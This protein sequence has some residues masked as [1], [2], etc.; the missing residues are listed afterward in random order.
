MSLSFICFLCCFIE[1]ETHRPRTS[2][3]ER[4]SKLRAQTLRAAAAR[5]APRLLRSRLTRAARWSEVVRRKAA[6][7]RLSS[8]F[9][10]AAL[11]STFS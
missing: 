9:R 7:D 1:F 8:R 6:A 2:R 10:Q 11:K 4:G 3:G 5:A